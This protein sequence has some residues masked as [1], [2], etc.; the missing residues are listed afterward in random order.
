M[1]KQNIYI[2]ILLG[3][4]VHLSINAQK[5]FYAPEFQAQPVQKLDSSQVV[6]EIFLLGDIKPYSPSGLKNLHI[7][8]DKITRSTHQNSV[9]LLGD[10]VYPLGMPDKDDKTY[11]DAKQALDTILNTFKGYKN[12][13]Y[14]I[15][16]NHDWARGRKQGWQHVLNLENYITQ[17]AP[18]S[19]KFL[20]GNACPGPV[21]IELT[22]DIVLV[23][24][25]SQWWLHQ[26]DKPKATDCGLQQKN[27]LFYKVEDI[28]K[29]NKEKKI[30]VTA[31]H[32]LFSVGN[33]GGY[34]PASRNLFPLLDVKKN[35]YI[36]LPGFLYTGYRKYIGDIQDLS[37]PEYKFY[38]NQLLN[39]FKNY[40]GIIYAAGH[41]HNLQYVVKDSLFHIISGAG[42]PG[43]YIARKQKKADFA[44]ERTGFVKLSFLKDGQVWIT[45]YNKDAKILLQTKMFKK[46]IFDPVQ[47]K[48]KKL[49]YH[50]EKDSVVVRISDKYIKAKKLQKKLLGQNYREIWNTPFKI[51]V[52]DI[53]KEKGGLKILKKGGG[54]QTFSVRLQAKDGKQYVLRSVD[55]HVSKALDLTFRNTFVEKPVQDAISASNPFGALTVPVL[56]DAIGVMHTNPKLFWLP[57]DPRFG[58]YQ[59]EL[60]N[61][62]FLFEE[63]PAGNWQ[64]AYFFGYSKKIISTPKM[65]KKI[66][67]KQT[68]SVDQKAVLKARLLDMLINDWDRH[69]DQWRWATFKENNKTLY[70]PIPRDRDQVYFVN[71]GA[72]MWLATRKWALRKF[73]GFNDTIT[74]I[75]GLNYNA[76]YFD[77][78]FLTGLSKNDWIKIAQ[79]IQE[80]INDSIIHS[81]IKKM[82][83]EIYP[84][85]GTNIEKTLKKRLK[86]LDKYAEEYYKILARNVDVTGTN[87]DDYFEVTRLPDNTTS[88]KVYAI[89][90]KTG[91]PVDTLFNRLFKGNETKEIRL[92]GLNGKDRFKI[93]GNV[94]K[95]IKIRIIGGKGKDSII[96]RSNVHAFGKKTLVYDRKDKKN[97]I[98]GSKE[99]KLL[100]SKKKSVNRYD[101]FQFKYNKTI[102][103]I[104]GGYN[105]DDGVFL[106]LGVKINRYNF[107]YKTIHTITAKAAFETGAYQL[108]YKG[109]F[110]GISPYYNLMIDAQASMPE[111]V[112]NFFGLG[113]DTQKL[114]DDKSYYR[115]RYKY[116]KIHPSFIKKINKKINLKAGLSYDFYEVTDTIGKFIGDTDL[117]G[118]TA[119][120]YKKQNY[121]GADLAINIDTRD[122]TLL[123]Q[124]GMKLNTNI[125]TFYNENRFSHT[126]I[127]SDWSVYLSFK[128]DP[129][130]VLAM[131]V[132]GAKNYGDYA[133]YHANYLGSNTNLRG[134]KKQRFAGD[135]YLYQNTELR[136]KLG[137]IHSY[138]LNGQTGINLFNDLGKVW[139]DGKSAGG[140]HNGYG[141]EYWL[142]PFEMGII[143]LSVNKS[144]EDFF[145]N[146]KFSYLF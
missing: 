32:P 121:F 92:Y 55:K 133:F 47:S 70:K 132:G 57:D 142:V 10:I 106:G 41:E 61:Q 68:Y 48:N 52:F 109:L 123:P 97:I 22:D 20:P 45:Y 134:Y 19:I 117:S 83:P 88:V 140:W 33:H 125:A 21:E 103:L 100:L 143:R 46:K 127:K 81:A 17:K 124:R 54:M 16:G 34:F 98:I 95:G 105:I 138:L 71:Q 122:R 126:N 51:P 108:K 3:I 53:G 144:N 72:A 87:Q 145:V 67:K 131:R 84:K 25:D 60:S 79:N 7:F 40:P 146:F 119:E 90:K 135:S 39:I 141:I 11:N 59:P 101:R 1:K 118:L 26:N 115:V 113:N 23:L 6:Y 36:P 69:D 64:D 43:S 27:E 76:R 107:R 58:V 13:V 37:H 80:K 99:T 78:S 82:P 66:R 116:A 110:T 4:F 50:P 75:A 15:A 139:Y 91:K 102:P 73:Q 94:K 120:E 38:K 74:D 77:R 8:H 62:V 31:H 111:Y 49:Q 56:A 9:V 130:T 2:I 24:I 42:G 85:I 28:L 112:N 18:E 14:I 136:I 29:R 86:Y 5:V 137:N 128:Q 35:L 65:L 30:V 12:K 93:K 114:I 96:D 44:Y 89:D 63:R 129:R 104:L